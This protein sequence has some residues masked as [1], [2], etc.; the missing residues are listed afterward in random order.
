MFSIGRQNPFLLFYSRITPRHKNSITAPYYS[1]LQPNPQSLKINKPPKR[2]IN[3]PLSHTFE[4]KLLEFGN[5]VT[6]SSS[7]T[8][9]V[10]CILEDYSLLK[11]LILETFVPINPNQP[12]P[13]VLRVTS[14]AMRRQLLIS[15]NP[16]IKNCIYQTHGT[17]MVSREFFDVTDDSRMYGK[18]LSNYGHI[19]A[20]THFDLNTK[21]GLTLDLCPRWLPFLL[22]KRY[23]STVFTYELD[24]Q[25]QTVSLA[26]DLALPLFSPYST[27]Y[28]SGE[29]GSN[30]N[31]RNRTHLR[32]RIV[33]RY[34][35]NSNDNKFN[36]TGQM[37]TG[38]IIDVP[39][40]AD[41]LRDLQYHCPESLP[42]GG[43]STVL[44]NYNNDMIIN[45]LQKPFFLR[46]DLLSLRAPINPTAAERIIYRDQQALYTYLIN[47]PA[48]PRTRFEM[49]LLELNSIYKYE[50]DK[51]FSSTAIS[52]KQQN[53]NN[54]KE[55]FY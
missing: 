43:G 47:N 15:P 11:A 5:R 37:V 20:K 35:K 24:I 25:K 38:F 40:S 32:Y 21:Y 39:Y 13:D 46:P 26:Y 16:N 23:L 6:Q 9:P 50:N 19:N 28:L 30:K 4:Q 14:A 41:E 7:A 42:W 1:H 51:N 55:T 17:G 49:D 44:P 34:R 10:H 18:Q 12:I 53:H 33:I 3:N 22:F 48:Q 52:V 54:N 29:G 45:P 31:D 27:E 8:L 2:K 36:P